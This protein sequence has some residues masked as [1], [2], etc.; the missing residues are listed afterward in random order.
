ME[1]F[2][3]RKEEPAVAKDPLK[4]EPNDTIQSLKARIHGLLGIPPHRQ[5]LEFAGEMLRDEMTLSD[6]GIHDYATVIVVDT[7]D[8]CTSSTVTDAQAGSTLPSS[9]QIVVQNKGAQETEAAVEVKPSDTI[10][11]LKLKIHELWGI[12]VNNQRL[13]F[14]NSTFPLDDGNMTLSD[15]NIR[16]GSTLIVFDGTDGAGDIAIELM[17]MTEREITGNNYDEALNCTEHCGACYRSLHAHRYLLFFLFVLAATFFGLSYLIYRGNAQMQQAVAYRDGMKTNCTILDRTSETCKRNGRSTYTK[18]RT[19]RYRRYSYKASN[20]Y[21]GDD[22]RSTGERC[23]RK[24]DDEKPWIGDEIVC[25]VDDCDSGEFMIMDDIKEL[26]SKGIWNI[27]EGSFGL[28]VF[29]MVLV[30]FCC[31]N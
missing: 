14:A 25:Y 1:I 18:G 8:G 23:P 11:S 21:C 26:K 6:C 31:M 24:N 2:V 17:E 19:R 16:D 10:Q 29:L 5:Q 27:I 22:L 12:P 4:V 7:R 30:R 13:A 9:V 20:G 28:F 15:Y 3:E